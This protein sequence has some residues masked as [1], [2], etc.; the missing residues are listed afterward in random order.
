MTLEHSHAI[1]N[2]IL[3]KG[4]ARVTS[5]DLQRQVARIYVTKANVI[6]RLG[7]LSRD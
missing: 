1:N 3:T 4:T 6:S 2:E 7:M 5:A